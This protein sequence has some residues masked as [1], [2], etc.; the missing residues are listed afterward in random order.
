MPC[1]TARRA[2]GLERPRR[3]CC[4]GFT[5]RLRWATVGGAFEALRRPRVESQ[6]L[7]LRRRDVE[8]GLEVRR[9]VGT[10]AVIL[11]GIAYVGAGRF[12]GLGN[13]WRKT[14]LVQKYPVL[15]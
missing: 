11:L 1:K 3:K 6:Q 12:L 8:A 10:G 7:G 9:G 2:G 4:N 15:E 5:T 14:A 13:R